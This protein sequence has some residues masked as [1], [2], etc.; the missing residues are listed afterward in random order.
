[1][2]IK[3]YGDDIGRVIAIEKVKQLLDGK[4]VGAKDEIGKQSGQVLQQVQGTIDTKKMELGNTF[5]NFKQQ[6]DSQLPGGIS[7]AEK[8]QG[9]KIED[10]LGLNTFMQKFDE[11]KNTAG[12]KFA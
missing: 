1:M 12:T 11:V 5:Q 7:T 2:L 3:N 9:K 8:L 4:L 10:I 6:L